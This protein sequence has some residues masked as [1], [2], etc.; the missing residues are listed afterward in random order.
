MINGRKAKEVQFNSKAELL[1]FGFNGRIIFLISSRRAWSLGV[2][3]TIGQ[4]RC[5]PLLTTIKDNNGIAFIREL[6]KLNIYSQSHEVRLDTAI[7]ASINKLQLA[8]ESV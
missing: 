2:S 6:K 7:K 4:Y 1:W 5:I 3:L 8:A